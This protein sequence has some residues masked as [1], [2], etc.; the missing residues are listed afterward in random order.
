[1]GGGGGWCRPSAPGRSRPPGGSRRYR[2]AGGGVV[3]SG[4]SGSRPTGDTTH[5]R[6][7]K[8]A[9]YDE[10]RATGRLE[11]RSGP[12]TPP[13]PPS[14]RRAPPPGSC[15]RQLKAYARAAHDEARATA[16]RTGAVRHRPS[17]RPLVVPLDVA[18][19]LS[20]VL[21]DAAL[22]LATFRPATVAFLAFPLRVAPLLPAPLPRM[23]RC[24]SVHPSIL[25][26]LHALR[27][28]VARRDAQQ[29]HEGESQK[30]NSCTQ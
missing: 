17:A 21:L 23:S 4:R 22:L 5:H 16:S 15:N 25:S 12:R 19:V 29:R 26:P 9:R 7:S 8:R 24:A 1:V 20:S 28:G 6:R 13:P 14:A 10:P 11:T 3:L 2:M 27:L 18:S 30:Q